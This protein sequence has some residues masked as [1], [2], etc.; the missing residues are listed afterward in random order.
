MTATRF[1]DQIQT[2]VRGR[3]LGLDN[4]RFMC[5][6]LGWRE[7]FETLSAA[8]TMETFGTTTLTGSTG[9]FTLLAP[10]KVGQQKEII[11]ASSVSTAAMAI[12]RST[13]NGAC[14]FVSL[15]TIHGALAADAEPAKRLNLIFV[16]SAVTLRAVSSAQWAVVGRPSTT[17]LS[18]ST[19]S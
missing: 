19:S 9:T 4:D 13:A 5:G 3:E 16:G 18:M 8:S 1:Q 10:E 11:N 15:S 2:S 12:V 14:S 7:P 17:F 6:P